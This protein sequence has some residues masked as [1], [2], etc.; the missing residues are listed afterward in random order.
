M[1]RV[2]PVLCL[3][4]GLGSCFSFAQHGQQDPFIRYLAGVKANQTEAALARFAN[5]CGL[6]LNATLPRYADRPD[7]SWVPV[8]DLSKGIHGLETDFFATVEVRRKSNRTL[9]ELW[10]MELDVAS[11]S[12]ILYCLD[13]GRISSMESVDWTLPITKQDGKENPGWGYEQH[14]RIGQDGKYATTLHRFIDLREQPT[15]VPRLDPETRRHLDW[16]PEVVTW[17]D[18]KLPDELLR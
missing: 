10:V 6:D 11:E 8:K 4:S 16:T 7:N 17:K 9:V 14:W 12:R 18:L 5:S 1:K 3:M 15:A 2:L 13:K